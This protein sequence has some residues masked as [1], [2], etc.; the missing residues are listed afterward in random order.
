MLS[1]KEEIVQQLEDLLL[2]PDFHLNRSACATLIEQYLSLDLDEKLE[3]G[4]IETVD[5]GVDQLPRQEEDEEESDS[6]EASAG[7]EESA[8]SETPEETT[9]SSPEMQDPLHEKMIG[10]I[11]RYHEQREKL[12]DEIR[13]EEGEN[14]KRKEGLLASFKKLIEEEEHIGKAFKEFNAIRDEWN[15]IGSVPEKE[16]Q[17]LHREYSR[18]SELFYYNIDIYKQLQ[19]HDLNRN[20]DLKRDVLEKLKSLDGEKNMRHL[21]AAVNEC[22]ERW[23]DIGPT[24]REEWDK[25]KEEFWSQVRTYYDLIRD[26]FQ[27]LREEQKEN[28]AKKEALLEEVKNLASLELNQIKK[29]QE[30]TDE[31]IAIQ[32]KWK[33]IGFATRERNEAIWKEFRQACDQFF[34]GKRDYFKSIRKEQD[35]NAKQKS[36]LIEKAEAL[37]NST[38]W[39]NTTQ[40]LIDL[41]KAWKK[42]GAAQQRDE[43]KLWKSF[44]AACDHFFESKKKFFGSKDDREKENLTAKEALIAEIEAFELSG[45]K[46]N[47]L[48]SLKAFSNR[49][50]EIDH[51]PFKE[52]DRVYKAYTAALDKHYQAMKMGKQERDKMEFKSRI[53]NLKSGDNDR[54]LDREER[55]LRDKMGKLNAEVI[56]LENNLGFFASS[57][58]ADVLKKEVE[59]KIQQAK[60]EI[61][62][63]EQKLRL[64]K[65]VK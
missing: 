27:Q 46:I 63:I 45:D 28:L 17:K 7:D 62:G 47:D 24:H 3:S 39:K 9:E 25:L 31:I 8:D 35:E 29:W 56:Q 60:D 55:F 20:L 33:T 57:K 54:Q 36:A 44:R 51:V 52:K 4:I 37:K 22:I 6:A 48:E 19:E 64:L 16:R 12:L 18:L 23:N 65:T 1:P 38:D 61:Q 10:L 58:G 5:E 32:E 26:H 50:N 43:Q 59:K 13:N 34:S 42:I 41:Q 14:L 40:A 53:E 2:K 11:D 49:F 21:D 15:E 30:K